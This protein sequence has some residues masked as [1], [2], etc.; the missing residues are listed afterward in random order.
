[1]FKNNHNKNKMRNIITL[2]L[3]F[4]T[5][6]FSSKPQ[7]ENKISTIYD[8]KV[9]DIDGVEFDLASLKDKKVMIVNVA[10]KCGLTPQYEQLQ[11]LYEEY[12]DKGF[13]I[14]GFPANNFNN[15]EPGAESEIKEFCTI[16]YGVTFP[17]MSKIS[18]VGD[19]MAPLYRWLTQKEHNGVKDQE[20][21]W[22]FQ[23][24]LID[25]NGQ[26][27]DVIMPKESPKNEKILKWLDAG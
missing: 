8:F 19:D 20:V 9:T 4:I 1:M 3:I 10:S 23:K 13:E 27:F 7:T 15:Q 24:F 11:E 16:N 5:M 2:F 25:K 12:H 21:T 17:M 26:L 22:N 6:A 18:V 14:I